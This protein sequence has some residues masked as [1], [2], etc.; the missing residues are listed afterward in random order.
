MHLSSERKFTL[1]PTTIPTSSSTT[2][3]MIII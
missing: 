2:F 1:N 3:V